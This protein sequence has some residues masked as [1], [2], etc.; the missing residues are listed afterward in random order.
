MESFDT[1]PSKSIKEIHISL[2]DEIIEKIKSRYPKKKGKLYEKEIKSIELTYNIIN[3]KTI[4]AI[5]LG[6]IL[7]KIHP[8]YWGLIEINFDKKE[9]VKSIN[10]IKKARKNAKEIW[11]NYRNNVLAAD[12]PKEIKIV[13][14]EARGRMLSYIKRCSKS[15]EYLKNLI[16]FLNDLPGI[17]VNRKTIIV[18]GPPNAGKSTFVSNVS[19]AKPEIASYPFTTKKI[20]IG[21]YKTGNELIQIIDT[22]GLLDRPLDQMNKVERQAISA[23]K[24]LDGIVLFILDPAEGAY[25]DIKNQV[26][27]IKEIKDL[28]ANKQIYIVINKIDSLNSEIIDKVEEEI[29]HLI[30]NLGIDIN[31]I[32]KASLKNKEDSINIL[33]NIITYL[34]PSS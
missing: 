24:F 28:I 11:I 23:L 27:I 8:F 7:E 32:F 22:P 14:R 2:Y 19:S 31:N 1:D 34:N 9:I 16:I 26:D 33:K 20:I 17:M 18:S 5:K 29:K 15:L 25:M 13:A 21:H 4:Q 12:N 10:C 6:K 30:D 3:S